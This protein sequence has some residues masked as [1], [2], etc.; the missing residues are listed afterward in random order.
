[1]GWGFTRQA[2]WWGDLRVESCWVTEGRHLLRREGRTS[3]KCS[4]DQ[5]GYSTTWVPGQDWG[6][7]RGLPCHLLVAGLFLAGFIRIWLIHNH[8]A[9]GTIVPSQDCCHCLLLGLLGVPVSAIA[10]VSVLHFQD[11]LLECKADHVML[12]N[13]FSVFHSFRKTKWSHGFSESATCLSLSCTI[14]SLVSLSIALPPAHSGP[15]AEGFMLFLG[16]TDAPRAS[17]HP[18]TFAPACCP[19]V[20]EALLS[21]LLKALT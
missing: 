21:D 13:T 6:F 18:R 10:P 11:V 15:D 3:A 4:V 7:G 16:H 8:R 5:G 12:L 17:S 2:P 19:S 14:N 9:Q 20:Y 1:M